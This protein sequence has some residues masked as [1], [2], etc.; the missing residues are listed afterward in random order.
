MKVTI[1]FRDTNT[2]T[3]G[4]VYGDAD[5]DAAETLKARWLADRAGQVEL[6]CSNATVDVDLAEVVDIAIEVA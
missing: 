6:V 5:L 2:I 3:V 1:T 4:P